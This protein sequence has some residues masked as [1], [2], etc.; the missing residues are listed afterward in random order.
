MINIAEGMNGI[1]LDS[2]CDSGHRRVK[3]MVRQST[4]IVLGALLV[5]LGVIS[6]GSALF[7]PI[8]IA[9]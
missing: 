5:V 1:G 6:P 8:P 7:R 2:L 3:R 4:L 9:Q